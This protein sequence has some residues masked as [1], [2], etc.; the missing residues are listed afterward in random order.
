[1]LV[2]LPSRLVELVQQFNFLQVVRFYVF[3]DRLLYLAYRQSQ[4]VDW[5][6]HA[7]TKSQFFRYR[8]DTAVLPN[9]SH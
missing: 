6:Y 1:M 8:W 7:I 4:G 9:Y 3:D 2:P 5:S